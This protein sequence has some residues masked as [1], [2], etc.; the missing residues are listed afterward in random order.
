VGVNLVNPGDGISE[1]TRTQLRVEYK[2]A[3]TD[4][5]DDTKERI[6]KKTGPLEP[7]T[8]MI[9]ENIVDAFSNNKM[10]LQTVFFAVFFGI[11]MLFIPKG[12]S[13]L[14]LD[15]FE[16]INAV[17]I[18]MID[19][20][21]KIAPIGVFALI[22]AQIASVP[23]TDLLIALG[24]YSLTVIGSLC[25]MLILYAL[26]ITFFTPINPLKFF[27]GLFPAQLLAFSSS[28]SAATRPLPKNQVEGRLGVPDEVSSFVLPLGA[29]VNM[30]GTSLYQAIAAVFIAQVY[31]IELDIMAQLGIVLTAL[32]SSIGAAGVP[33]A[34]MILLGVILAQQGLP[35]EGI[36]LVMAPDRLLDMCRT[37]INVT[38]D[39]TVATI[40]AHS[41]K[42]LYHVK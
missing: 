7:L 38:G 10:M 36:A 29:T 42:K 39:A 20:I 28:S 25:A 40:V 5:V 34:G 22:A 9:P 33:G 15:F 14:L 21:M 11:V 3:T 4:A 17:I 26:V 1:E 37:T 24:S 13:Q 23:S 16:A 6:E 30:D 8:N 2:E 18:K 35:L 19:F 27:R 31:G 32:L 41:E 12:Q